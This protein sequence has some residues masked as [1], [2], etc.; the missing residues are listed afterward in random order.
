MIQRTE[1]VMPTNLAIDDRLT[2][3]A[4]KLGYHRTKKETVWAALGE[5]IKRRK[6]QSIF[7][8]FGD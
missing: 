4:R 5:N 1:G 7:S 2:E 6:Q 3:E 8:L